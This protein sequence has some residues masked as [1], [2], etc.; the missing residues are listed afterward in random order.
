[1]H[2][3]SPALSTHQQQSQVSAHISGN[4]LVWEGV[5][6]DSDEDNE[7]EDYDE[8][9]EAEYEYESEDYEDYDSDND[10][11][12][13]SAGTEADTVLT[14]DTSVKKTASDSEAQTEGATIRARL[15]MKSCQ[16][17]DLTRIGQL[18]TTGQKIK[19]YKVGPSGLLS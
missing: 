11:Y 13:R 1:M 7:Y 6:N 17:V 19:Y 3:H 2:Y 9:Y 15:E 5:L 4:C 8:Y 18:C 16:F 14:T 12:D 10:D